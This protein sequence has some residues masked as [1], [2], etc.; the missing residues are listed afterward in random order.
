[1]LLRSFRHVWILLILLPIAIFAYRAYDSP[2]PSKEASVQRG[3]ELAAEKQFSQ[4]AAVY[5][6]AVNQDPSDGRLRLK[7]ANAY[8][9]DQNWAEALR[10]TLRAAEL[11]PGD[12]DVSMLAAS[13]QLASGLFV[14]AAE[15]A[16]TLLRERPSDVNVIILWGNATA[17]LL[18]SSW[19]L[20]RLPSNMGSA[21]DFELA[22]KALRPG[23]RESEDAAAEEA[24]RKALQLAPTLLEAQLA[25]VNFLWAA[26]RADEGESLLRQTADQNPGHALVTHALGAYYRLRNRPADAERYLR[27]AAAAGIYGFG[28]RVML[29]DLYIESHRDDDALAVLEA[30]PASDDASGD[31]TLRAAPIEFRLGKHEAALSRIES[32]LVREPRNARALLLKAQFLLAMKRLDKALPAARAATAAARQSHEARTT[33]AKALTAADDLEGALEEYAEAVRLGAQQPHKELA[34]LALALGR[35][36]MS[37]EYARDAARYLPGDRESGILLVRALIQNGDIAGAERQLKPLLTSTPTAPDVLI[38]LGAIEEARG[39]VDAARAAY[40]RAYETDRNS[41]E[42]L[43]G[44]VSLAIKERRTGAVVP[45]MD[46]A[47]AA[48]PDDPAYLLLASRVFTAQHDERRTESAL[49]RVLGINPGHVTAAL[50]LS[51]SL[52]RQKR[53]D[54]AKKVLEQSLERNPRSIDVQTALGVQLERMGDTQGARARYKSILAD[55]PRAVVAS[56]RLAALI[57]AQGENLDTALSLALTAVKQS[58]KDPAANDLVGWIYVKKDLAWYALPYLED[59]VRIAPDNAAYR[60]HLGM[61][62]LASGQRAKAQSEMTRSV[63]I[64]AS[65]TPAREALASLR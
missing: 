40:T 34:G 45:Q 43:S 58:P 8:A 52:A 36:K 62:Y 6:I 33:L 9:A 59:A 22:R 63:E 29:A 42:A 65:F 17:R 48:H 1:V 21:D 4:A 23:V 49:R 13:R 26:G 2:R 51:D 37:L 12:F 15:R 32:F 28:A 14:D 31:V 41:F 10:E 47:L 38:Q 30:M 64:D 44:I 7:L 55:D 24:F 19:A 39:H 3:D 27:N 25:M 61:A 56:Q 60:F 16:S 46:A 11:L 20:Y 5:R 57:V 35:Q 54:E 18:N 50:S 53:H